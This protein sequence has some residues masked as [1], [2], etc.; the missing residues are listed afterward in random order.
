VWHLSTHLL[1][2]I[3]LIGG[4][5]GEKM[6]ISKIPII[7]VFGLP[8]IIAWMIGVIPFSIGEGRW[9]GLGDWLRSWFE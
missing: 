1:K 5:N 6:R 3:I 9:L 7:L 8:M 4:S 2:Y